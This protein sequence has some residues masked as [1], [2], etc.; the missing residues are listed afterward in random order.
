M[1]PPKLI[2][3]LASWFTETRQQKA[4]LNP[5]RVQEKLL[6]NIL[7]RYK[8]TELGHDFNLAG[9]TS[10]AEFS[11]KIPTR[12]SI[13]HSPWWEKA[14]SENT[15]GIVHPKKL[16]YMALSSGTSGNSKHIPF[17]DEQLANFRKFSNHV[18]FHVFREL[19]DYSLLDENILITSSLGLQERPE[20]GITLGYSSGLA[21]LHSSNFAKNLIR[22]SNDILEISNWEEKI[23]KTIEQAFDLDIRIVTG[24]PLP[25]I[26]LLE[27][28]ISY[29]NSKGIPATCAKDIWPNLKVYSYSGS[30]L[31]IFE[32][33]IKRLLGNGVE[34]VEF[35][36]ST[37]A[38]I[39]Y[40]YKLGKKG[41]LVDLLSTYY[42]FEPINEDE[43]KKLGRR[44][45][46]HEIEVGIPYEITITTVGGI[47]AYSLGDRVEFISTKPYVLVFSGRNKEEINI[48][49]EH[50]R[51]EQAQAI[52]DKTCSETQTVINQ[53]LVCPQ[54]IKGTKVQG[55]EWCIEFETPPHNSDTFLKLLDKNFQE[56][57]PPYAFYRNGNSFGAPSLY[58]LS[59]GTIDNYVR[60]NVVFGQG[61]LLHLHNDRRIV[62]KII[63]LDK[64]SEETA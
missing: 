38:P 11:Q 24:V 58:H 3:R 1:K 10:A 52:L 21:T 33:K 26:A 55:Y 41:L 25:F 45:G 7:K 13:E 30:S 56:C 2:L 37:E 51:L 8:N 60:E 32:G 59:K 6:L 16:R 53:F 43:K 22:P 39:A 42:E 9:I 18:F 54:D 44:L 64:K 49:N 5:Q 20:T 40:Q 63:A 57:N 62:E 36:S 29:A 19:N 12:T 28:L 23:H 4:H 27:Y 17:P 61:K 31:D 47:F 34:L 35:Y 14:L 50:L 15:E 46:I 48:S